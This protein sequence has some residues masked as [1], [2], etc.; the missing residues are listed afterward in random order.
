[1][2]VRQFNHYIQL[3]QRTIPELYLESCY[4]IELTAEIICIT[5]IIDISVSLFLKHKKHVYFMQLLSC[6]IFFAIFGK[7][8]RVPS[9]GGRTC[10]AKFYKVLKK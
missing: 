7:M 8:S 5:I 9:Y 4:Y 6:D 10:D 1:M 2:W 3:S